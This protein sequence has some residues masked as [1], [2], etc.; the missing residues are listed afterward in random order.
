MNVDQLLAIVADLS[1]FTT[2]EQ[3]QDRLL[4]CQAAYDQLKGSRATSDGAD[5]GKAKMLLAAIAKIENKIAAL[6]FS[7]RRE[8]Q[9]AIKAAAAI[10]QERFAATSVKGHQ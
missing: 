4:Q 3:L 7:E 9:R 6:K 1:M 5:S 10:P 2:A 8:A